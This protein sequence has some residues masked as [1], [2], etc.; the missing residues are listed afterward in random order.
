MKGWARRR[1]W[2]SPGSALTTMIDVPPGAATSFAPWSG[3]RGAA[4]YPSTA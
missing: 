3:S 2:A 1:A 4:N